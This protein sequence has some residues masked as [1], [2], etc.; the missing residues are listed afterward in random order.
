MAQGNRE[1]L[2][3]G[4]RPPINSTPSPFIRTASDLQKTIIVLKA[5][6]NDW[7]KNRLWIN[8][9]R[10]WKGGG[11]VTMNFHCTH[12]ISSQSLKSLYF[13]N[14]LLLKKNIRRRAE[15]NKNT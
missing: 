2:S 1:L 7:Q 11:A 13:S 3:N 5:S 14:R 15:K 12:V 9:E 8:E 10:G 6:R 4:H